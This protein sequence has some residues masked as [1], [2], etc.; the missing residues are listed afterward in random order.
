MSDNDV[1]CFYWILS[2]FHVHTFLRFVLFFC[3]F[4]KCFVLAWPSFCRLVCFVSYSSASI[5]I[6]AVSTQRR[7]IRLKDFACSSLFSTA[8]NTTTQIMPSNA[9][10]RKMRNKTKCCILRKLYGRKKTMIFIFS[11]YPTVDDNCI[12][13]ITMTL[14]SKW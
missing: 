5:T 12:N 6:S 13:I 3:F 8:N 11:S 9:S 10:I 2:I 1:P 7:F 4:F 14:Q